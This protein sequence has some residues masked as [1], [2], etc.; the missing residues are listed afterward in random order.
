MKYIIILLAGMCYGQPITNQQMGGD[1][2]LTL[3]WHL[4]ADTGIIV[5]DTSGNNNHGE[6]FDGPVWI[7][8]L[9]GSAI[10][11]SSDWMK[12]TIPLTNTEGAISFWYNS[13]ASAGEHGMM[14]IENEST[15]G[16]S[17]FIRIIIFNGNFDFMAHNYSVGTL[18][19]AEVPLPA[20]NKWHRVTLAV[21]SSGNKFYVNG[22]LTSP[23]YSSGSASSTEWFDDIELNFI[24][25]GGRLLGGGSVSTFYNGSVEEISL[26]DRALSV[27]EIKYSY[28]SQS[29]ARQ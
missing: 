24:Y 2:A 19:R 11:F 25:F 9:W 5:Y 12:V 22:V 4:N 27:A 20:I 15:A 8:G 16:Q 29:G 10:D 28:E 17:G 14:Y 1:T 3:L 21:D 23:T 7:D 13:A 6:L 26:F 18:Y